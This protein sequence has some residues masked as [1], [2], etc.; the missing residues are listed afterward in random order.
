VRISAII[1]I[2]KIVERIIP[3]SS[4]R[5]LFNHPPIFHFSAARWPG[6]VHRTTVIWQ[7][8][9]PKNYSERDNLSQEKEYIKRKSA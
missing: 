4:K 8:R 3:E 9:A 5:C 6:C 2:T 1:E 7:F